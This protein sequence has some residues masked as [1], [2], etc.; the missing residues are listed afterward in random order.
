MGRQGQLLGLDQG[1][2]QCSCQG[3]VSVTLSISFANPF[4][5]L[6]FLLYKISVKGFAAKTTG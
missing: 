2:G 3:W 1:T 5:F 6:I 4:Q